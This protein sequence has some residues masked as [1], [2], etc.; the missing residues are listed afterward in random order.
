M[1]SLPGPNYVS[2]A[3]AAKR[4]GR[5]PDVLRRWCADGRLPAIRLGRAWALP[6]ESVALLIAESGRSRPRRVTP[7]NGTT[8][9]ESVSR[10]P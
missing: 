1:T 4:T 7:R 10:R 6:K 3:E 2:L 9:G 8:P 5:H